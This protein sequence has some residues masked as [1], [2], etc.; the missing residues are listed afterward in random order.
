MPQPS[1]TVL[2]IKGEWAT[3]REWMIAASS[4]PALWGALGKGLDEAA[5]GDLEG[6]RPEDG[7]GANIMPL[8]LP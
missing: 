3:S 5:L 4:R 2:V 1:A 8:P 6:G 7:A